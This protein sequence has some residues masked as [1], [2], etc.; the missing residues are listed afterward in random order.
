MCLNIFGCY[1]KNEKDSRFPTYAIKQNIQHLPIII[2]QNV[3]F[4]YLYI[5]DLCKIIEFFI[6]N[7]FPKN[8]IINVTP[9]E[10]ISLKEIAEIVNETSNFKS[11]IIIKNPVLNFEYTG[12]NSKLLKLIPDLKFT[13]HKNGLKVFYEKFKKDN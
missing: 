3:V 9:S 5:D 7:K 6:K 2:N 12:D 13:S 10:S 8:N 1:G 11:E 4:D